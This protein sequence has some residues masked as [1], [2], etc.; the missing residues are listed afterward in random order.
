MHIH[1]RPDDVA[2]LELGDIKLVLY[3]DPYGPTV[4]LWFLRSSG[5]LLLD[6]AVGVA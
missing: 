5:E 6:Q 4:A 3:L 1:H 2:V